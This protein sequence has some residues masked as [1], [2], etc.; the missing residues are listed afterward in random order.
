M[1]AG[2]Y[3]RPTYQ[4]FAHSLAVITLVLPTRCSPTH[5]QWLHSSYLP[6]VCPLPALRPAVDAGVFPAVH[7]DRRQGRAASRGLCLHRRPLH[8]EVRG[9]FQQTT[10]PRS[11]WN[12]SAE[13]LRCSRCIMNRLY[14]ENKNTCSY[15]IILI[16]FFQKFHFELTSTIIVS[17]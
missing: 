1:T 5:W 2:G 3:T 4:V 11:E 15:F 8:H 14:P 12:F 9:T 10:P 17:C 7:R 6:G 13:L 16:E